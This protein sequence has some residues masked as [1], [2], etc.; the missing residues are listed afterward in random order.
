MS[1]VVAQPLPSWWAF[2]AVLSVIVLISRIL[3][4]WIKCYFNVFT[5]LL[6]YRVIR[7]FLVQKFYCPVATHGHAT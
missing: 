6:F 3:F 4:I 7:V 1:K 2:D 5:V